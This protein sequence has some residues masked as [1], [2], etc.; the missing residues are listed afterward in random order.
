MGRERVLYRESVNEESYWDLAGKKK[1]L[2][3]GFSREL[4]P[5]LSKGLRMSWL[6][7]VDKLQSAA[8]C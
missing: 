8:L 4:T 3:G 7:E 6:V 5:G 2:S 1:I